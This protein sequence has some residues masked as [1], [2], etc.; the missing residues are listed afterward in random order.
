MA[1]EH[2][3]AVPPPSTSSTPGAPDGHPDA[4]LRAL[5]RE[6]GTDPLSVV[7]TAAEM[8]AM[9][10]SLT[11][12]LGARGATE[13][14]A[15]AA[16][17]RECTQCQG[18][19]AFE[20]A[21]LAAALT[22]DEGADARPVERALALA[23]GAFDPTSLPAAA[24]VEPL[25]APGEEARA[26]SP[27][28]VAARPSRPAGT[29]GSGGTGGLLAGL[30]AGRLTWRH[31]VGVFVLAAA[32]PFVPAVIRSM[33][34]PSAPQSA[35]SAQSARSATATTTA[36][37]MVAPSGVVTS[38]VTVPAGGEATAGDAALAPSPTVASMFDDAPVAAAGAPVAAAPATAPTLPAANLPVANAAVAAAPAATAAAA[39]PS[40]RTA[41]AAATPAGTDVLLDLGDLGSFPTATALRSTFAAKAPALRQSLLAN[42]AAIAIPAQATLPCLSAP[43]QPIRNGAHAVVGGRAVVILE[44]PYASPDPAEVLR[45]LVVLDAATCSAIA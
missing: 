8:T 29:G 14:L 9:D 44:T 39:T 28:R 18:R 5:L 17:L 41:S 22:A 25:A 13:L 16:H 2:L 20:T 33:R 30:A 6:T 4:A 15:A 27:R 19:T 35:Q 10:P 34:I 43:G 1:D 36:G 7:A 26:G 40:A 12:D 31:V 3:P 24:R 32:I 21:A 23:L 42:P 45:R 37:S 11:P 38:V